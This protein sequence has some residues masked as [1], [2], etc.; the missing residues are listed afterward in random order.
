MIALQH[1]AI[2]MSTIGVCKTDARSAVSMC[3]TLAAACAV[4]DPDVIRRI[5]ESDLDCE[6][7]IATNAE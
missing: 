2:A 4:F 1:G 3:T 5:R 6:E 7:D